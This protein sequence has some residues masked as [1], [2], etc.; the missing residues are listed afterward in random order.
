[1]ELRFCRIG[2]FEVSRNHRI[3][4]GQLAN[5]GIGNVRAAAF[6]EVV[7]E[8]AGEHFS[9]FVVCRKERSDAGRRSTRNRSLGLCPANF[10]TTCNNKNIYF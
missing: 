1:M 7:E 2:R 3:S 6:F 8:D 4:S 5:P 10:R 9:G